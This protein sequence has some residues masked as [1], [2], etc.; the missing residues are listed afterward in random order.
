M[1]VFTN[2]QNSNY[3]ILKCNLWILLLYVLLTGVCNC[4]AQGSKGLEVGVGEIFHILEDYHVADDQPP[5]LY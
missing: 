3:I 1:L 2:G 5:G 4:K